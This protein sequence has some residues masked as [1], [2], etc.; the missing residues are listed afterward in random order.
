LR[1]AT[2]AETSFLDGLVV[3]IE[4]GPDGASGFGVAKLELEARRAD[5]EEP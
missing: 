1:A 4:V 3:V 2:T 5:M